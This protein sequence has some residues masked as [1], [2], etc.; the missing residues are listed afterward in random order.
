MTT[1][2][3]KQHAILSANQLQ[4]LDDRPPVVHLRSFAE[5]RLQISKALFEDKSLLEEVIL[6]NG[7]LVGPVVAIGQPGD[8]LPPLGVAR[9][10]MP[11]EA[12]K[13]NVTRWIDEAQLIVIAV[14]PSPGLAWEATILQKRGLLAK[15]IFVIHTHGDIPYTVKNHC[16]SDVPKPLSASNSL[17]TRYYRPAITASRASTASCYS[18]PN[19]SR[20]RKFAYISLHL[21]V[22]R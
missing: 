22:L 12:W 19:V 3:A 2:L 7:M 18:L 11:A 6:D 21:F 4:R 16:Y 20:D 8:L 15:S 10:Y 1:P 13:V 5:E 9:D 17:S 14:G